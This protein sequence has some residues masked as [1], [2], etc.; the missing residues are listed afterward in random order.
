MRLLQVRRSQWVPAPAHHVLAKVNL[1]SPYENDAFYDAMRERQAVLSY[2]SGLLKVLDANV[3]DRPTFEG[4]FEVVTSLPADRGR[5]ATWPVATVFPYLAR[6]D[7]FM[8]LKPEVTKSAAESL[9][10]D[11]K[12]R[13][14]A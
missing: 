8:F 7:R 11:L 3:A 1:L 14:N 4:F 6:P 5:V 12:V 10:F 2:F 9:G 13:C